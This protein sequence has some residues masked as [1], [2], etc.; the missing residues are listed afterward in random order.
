MSLQG[1]YGG[2][3]SGLI[4]ISYLGV[5][6]RDA[7]I[8]PT[9]LARMD[10][11]RAEED[12]LDRELMRHVRILEEDIARND[13]RSVKLGDPDAPL[14]L[15]VRGGSVFSMPGQL[16]T[17]VFTGMTEVVAEALA[18]EDEWF[19]W[20]AY[21]RFLASYAAAAWHFDLEGLDLVEKAKRSHSV[22]L[23]TDLPGSA[24]REVV[25]ASKAA[26]REAGHGAELDA[27][28]D[29]AE[30]Q[31]KMAMR[32]AQFLEQRA[33]EALPGHQASQRGLAHGRDRPGN[34]GRKPFQP[35]GN[36]AGHG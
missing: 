9:V 26:I 23:K 25:E 28:L 36:E 3:G 7:F 12:R 35:G 20:D 11:Q 10:L 34:G 24:M 1:R 17:V 16:A 13:G 14:L 21:R 29:D 4:Y 19:A 22:P 27:L 32:A 18:R 5:P 31:V 6:T 8:I 30:L 33:R 15:A 2:K